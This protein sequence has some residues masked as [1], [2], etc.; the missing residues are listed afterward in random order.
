MSSRESPPFGQAD[1]TNCERELIHLSGSIQ[2]HGVLLVLSEPRL[3]VVQVSAN[4]EQHLGWTTDAIL[5][6]PV[7]SLGSD[8]ARAVREI[9]E[10]SQLHAPLPVQV[11]LRAERGERAATMLLHRP[12]A[13]GVIV[14]FEDIRDAGARRASAALPTRLAGIVTRLHGP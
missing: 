5:G 9:L 8:C 4:I 3:V 7:D 10:A 1:L 6:Q 11:T 12:P 13:G 14:E 2:P